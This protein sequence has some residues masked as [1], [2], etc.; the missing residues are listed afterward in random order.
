MASSSFRPHLGPNKIFGNSQKSS[1][2]RLT[3]LGDDPKLLTMTTR[4]TSLKRN[5][6]NE[7][8][9]IMAKKNESTT[10]TT[11]TVVAEPNN[12]AKAIRDYKAAN[13]AAGPSEI[14]KALTAQGVEVNASRVSTVLKGGSG[15][16]KVDVEQ[17]KKAA[18]FL[19]GFG[20]KADDAKKAIM[21]VGGFVSE[22]G[23]PEKAVAALDAYAALALALK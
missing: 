20:G 14:A 7:G 17:I 15:G 22:C 18:E 1:G 5:P 8:Q 21:S 4:L 6:N 9:T 19:K 10:N 2:T 3:V 23:S 11:T 16:S 12:K 13:P